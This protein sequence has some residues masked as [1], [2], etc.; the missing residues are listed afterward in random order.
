MMVAL[1]DFPQPGPFTSLSIYC[2]EIGTMLVRP[3]YVI[4]AVAEPG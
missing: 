3:W 4:F 2:G 1:R